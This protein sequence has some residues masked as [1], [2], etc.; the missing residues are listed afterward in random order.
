MYGWP[1]LL[2]ALLSFT[3]RAESFILLEWFNKKMPNWSYL[4]ARFVSAMGSWLDA[5]NLRNRV[6]KIE[7]ENE[8]LRIALQDIQR[9]DPDGRI[10]WYAREVLERVS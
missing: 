5:S 7:E 9:M 8:M 10:G 2:P 1:C 4:I 3:G 6:Y